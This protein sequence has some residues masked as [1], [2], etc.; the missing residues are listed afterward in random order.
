MTGP[1][2]AQRVQRLAD[3]EAIKDITARYAAAVSKGGTEKP[4]T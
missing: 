3:I 4:W 2:L 1:P